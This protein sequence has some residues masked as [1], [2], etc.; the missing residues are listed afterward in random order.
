MPDALIQGF[1]ILDHPADMGF[2]AWA[3]T[4]ESLFETAALALTSILVDLDVIEPT[5]TVEV[6]VEGEDD[7][8][9]LYHWLSE[10]IFLFDADGLLLSKF[11]ITNVM[12]TE[13]GLK[14]TAKVSGQEYSSDKHQI[15]TYVKAI[16]LHQLKVLRKGDVF[17]AQVYLDI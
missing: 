1:E 16:T 11:T 7:D 5:H 14:L 12:T 17:E 6:E 8:M 10:V 4:R 9:L 2:R 3:L 15:K 13:N